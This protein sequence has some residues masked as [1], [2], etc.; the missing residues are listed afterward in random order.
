MWSLEADWW[1]LVVRAVVIYGALLVMVRASGKR[2]VGQF[3]PFDLLVV[4]LL[5]EGVS[6]SLRGGDESLTGGLLVALVLIA[7][8]RLVAWSAAHSRRIEGWVDGAPVLLGRDGALY[9]GVL[10]GQHISSGD[11]EKALR[12]ADCELDDM[13]TMFL[14]PDGTISIQK[15]HR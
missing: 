6:N 12:E 11:V 10:R 7:L 4:L 9:D 5:S 3:T 8:N 1:E 2:T 14:E 13:R 15:K